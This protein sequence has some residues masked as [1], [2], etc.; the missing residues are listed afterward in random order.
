MSKNKHK[1]GKDTFQ[2]T[3][4]LPIIQYLTNNPNQSFNYKQL[5]FQL[6]IVDD[7]GKGQLAKLLAELVEKGQIKETDKG[8]FKISHQSHYYEGKMD[9]TMSGKAY[10]ICDE[11]E[12][13]I[14]IPGRNLNHALHGDQV[15]VYSYHRQRSNTKR[16]GDVVEILKRAKTE[17]VG[18]IQLHKN[19]AFVIPDDVRM[20]SDFFIPL[21]HVNDAKDGDKVVVKLT[22]WPANSKNPFGKILDVL[23]K[24]GDHN[25][26]IH[27][28]LLEYGLPYKFPDGVEEEANEI[29]IEITAEEIAKR[30]DMRQA[31]TFTIDPKDAKDFDDAISFEILPN[32]HYEI[33]IHIADVSHYVVPGTK[34]DK[35][36]YNRATSVYL[37]DR[38]VPMLPEILS[39][40]VCSLRPNEDKL[41]FS[42][43]F[44]MNRKAEVIKQWFGRTIIHSDKRYAYEDAQEIIEMNEKGSDNTPLEFAI[45]ELDAL[46]KILRG[47][48][49]KA[50][51]ITFDKLE[52]R[53]ELNTFNEPIQILFKHS[54]DANKLIEEF[55]LLANRKVAEFIGQKSIGVPSNKTFVY[56]IHDEPNVEKLAQLQQIIGKFGYKIDTRSTEK[57]AQSLNKLLEDIKDKPE[58]NMIETLTIRSMAKAIYTTK[59][60]GHYGLAFEYYTH[61]TSPIRRYPDV[62]VHRLLQHYLDGK[63]SPAM[64]VYEEQSKHSSE[65]EGLATKAER[66]SIKYMQVKYMQNHVHE[67][68]EGVVSGVTEW[69][70]FVELTDNMCEGLVRTKEI[71]DDYYLYDEKQVALVG[72]ATKN[73]IRLGDKVKVKVKHTDLEKKQLDFTLVD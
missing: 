57:L 29:N 49:V 6:N 46:A 65:R 21:K 63:K 26:E 48:R 2:E 8:K 62:M 23:G 68:F 20:Y 15:R 61:F 31:L 24:P 64:A 50:G 43:V 17:F 59:N 34:L 69:G 27:S 51:A 71:K 38:V 1:K 56:R 39:N 5:A 33:G 60:I 10:F 18:T 30:R 42:A 28:I 13:D 7:Y 9:I 22:D 40:N 11:L 37:V 4:T 12:N 66:D 16:E 41:T 32:G 58:E 45:L 72:Q 73:L 55:M 44:E 36:A 3:F 70:I 53:F 19:H 35:E 52:V 54:K 47:K 14:H 67:Q 25:T